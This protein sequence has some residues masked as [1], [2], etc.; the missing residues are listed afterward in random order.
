M[1]PNLRRI[2]VRTFVVSP[3]LQD[4][5]SLF[6]PTIRRLRILLPL[7]IPPVRVLQ[8]SAQSTP[9]LVKVLAVLISDLA[10]GPAPTVLPALLEARIQVCADDALVQLG[11]ADVLEAV[12]GVL[13]GKVLDEAEAA[14]GL[15][16]A[17]EPHDEALD[18]AALAKQLVHL[19]LGR[20]E[21]EVAHVQ[22]RRVREGVLGLLLLLL[23]LGLVAVLAAVAVVAVVAAPLVEL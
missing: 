9:A 8:R 3:T 1:T 18:L 17:V 12:E 10:A 19:L 4:A 21:G 14:W 5:N 15:V 16:E 22:R 7:A 13:V 6:K 23:L 20:E 11:A 2:R